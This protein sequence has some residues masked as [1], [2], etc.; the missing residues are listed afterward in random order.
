MKIKIKILSPV[1]IGNGNEISPIEYF[2]H[3]EQFIR[4]NM[5]GLFN[6]QDFKIL[7]EK[8]INSA[9]SERYI[10]SLLPN[11]LLLKHQLYAIKISENIKGEKVNPTNVKEHIK[12]AG[13]VYIPGSSLK[14]C[15]LSG[16]LENVL[17]QKRINRLDNFEELLSLSLST[18][19]KPNEYN[20]GKF[21]NWLYISDTDFKNPSECLELSLVKVIGART[22]SLLPILYETIK[23]NVEF[24]CEIKSKCKFSE[25]EILKM[26]EEFYK[27]VYIK[28]KDYAKNKSIIMPEIPSDGYILRI[29]QGSTAWATSFLILAEELNIKN[30]D[31][32]RP[33]IQKIKG[34]PITRK[35]SSGIISMGWIKI[36]KC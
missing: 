35:L 15:I 27:K 21:I 20:L 34:P 4:I 36:T 25:E 23:P 18:I 1:H 19:K 29:G 26:A 8:F 12:S 28:E 31:I 32:Q 13:R 9:Y 17:S 22:K 16:I 2:L 10:G 11:D 24:T 30:Y 14:G 33:Q 7:Q 3:N 6:D 5:E